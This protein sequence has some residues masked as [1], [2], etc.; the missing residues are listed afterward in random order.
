MT[1]PSQGTW[2]IISVS[3]RSPVGRPVFVARVRTALVDAPCVVAVGRADGEAVL[4]CGS[5]VLQSGAW[6]VDAGSAPVESRTAAPPIG[7]EQLIRSKAATPS[8]AA[9]R[10]GPGTPI[11]PM[12][13]G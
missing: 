1:R 10:A 5:A 3:P 8:P 7:A 9:T 4:G 13:T 12:C 6:V 11:D 2:L